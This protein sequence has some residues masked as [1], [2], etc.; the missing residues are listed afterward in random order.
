MKT[1]PGA[2][3]FFTLAKKELWSLTWAKTFVPVMTLAAP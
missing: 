2:R 3:S 1:P